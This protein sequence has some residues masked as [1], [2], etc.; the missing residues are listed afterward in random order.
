MKSIPI[1]SLLELIVNDVIT[2]PKL[3]WWLLKYVGYY[4]KTC[5]KL[6]SKYLFLDEESGLDN[7][8]YCYERTEEEIFL[9]LFESLDEFLEILRMEDYFKQEVDSYYKILNSKK[10]V[11]KWVIKNEKLGAEQLFMFGVECL[12]LDD[13]E[14]RVCMY[15]RDNININIERKE[16]KNLE[17]FFEIFNDLFWIKEVYPESEILKKIKKGM[18]ETHLDTR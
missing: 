3:G 15:W 12:D 8:L 1:K 14:K 4:K 2:T 6:Y 17:R 18:K 11:K 9:N 16:L 7:L 13:K 5:N 10:K